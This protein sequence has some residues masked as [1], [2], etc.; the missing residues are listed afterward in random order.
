MAMTF[1]QAKQ[2][3]ARNVGGSGVSG[4]LT[5]AGQAVI[6]AIR[7]LDSRHNWEFRL[8]TLTDIPVVAGTADYTLT[9][10]ETAVKR[11]HSARLKTNKRV[12]GYARQRHV[13]RALR[14]QEQNDIS[15]AY[16]EVVTATAVAIRLVPTPS[17]VDTLQVRV[18]E[19]IDDSYSDGDN[20]NIPDR[21]LPALLARARYNFLIDRDAEDRR[22]EAFLSVSEQQIEMAIRD[23]M[24]N[25]DED[26]R[27]I[28]QDEWI[29]AYGPDTVIGQWDG[30]W[31]W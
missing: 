5:I 29:G 14:N 25:P 9:P 15:V 7:H 28:P 13:D 4:Q 6:D 22:A 19:T 30:G 16:V 11:I 31:G 26:V 3:V 20:L 2:E 1:L 23:D 18:Y 12:L 17:T 10:S 8:K 21:Y 24:G 27:M